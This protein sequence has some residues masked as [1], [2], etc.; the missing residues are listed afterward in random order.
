MASFRAFFKQ[1][2]LMEVRSL[3]LTEEVLEEREQLEAIM[4]SLQ[5]QI[6]A[7]LSKIDTL[8]QEEKI[9]EQ[10]EADIKANKNFTYKVKEH[11]IVKHDMEGEGWYVTNCIT[12]NFTCHNPCC[13]PNNDHKRG[14]AAMSEDHCTV[15]PGQCHWTKHCNNPFWF[16]LEEVTVEK[17]YDDL[18]KRYEDAM[19]GKSSK[20]DVVGMIRADVA[21]RY[22]EV[23]LM[24]R[25]AQQILARLD[26]IALRPNPL[27]EVEYIDLLI[28]SEKQ[29]GKE[30]FLGRVECLTN[31]RQEAKFLSTVRD[32]KIFEDDALKQAQK[33]AKAEADKKGIWGSTKKFAQ[34]AWKTLSGQ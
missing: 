25:R 24:I 13:I 15:C 2:A 28:Q 16:E 30:G 21:A 5:P 1:L 33:L 10:H 9:M 8:K 3:Q 26:E 34:S 20:E 17:T 14:C 12:C 7:I 18:K 6:Q 31:V 11:K 4:Q 32:D 19:C 29:Q 27:S 23:F 22:H